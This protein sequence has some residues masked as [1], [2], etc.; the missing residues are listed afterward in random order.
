VQRS[1]VVIRVRR[2]R[3]SWRPHN[4]VC[5]AHKLPDELEVG[6]PGRIDNYALLR[7]CEILEQRTVLTCGKVHTRRCPAAEWVALRSLH[8]DD[9]RTTI[10]ENACAVTTGDP[11]RQIDDEGAF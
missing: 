4:D 3:A 8:L 6:L 11:T 2:Y 9:P 7:A 1:R 5:T 10:G